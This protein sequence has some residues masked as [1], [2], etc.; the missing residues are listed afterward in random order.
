MPPHDDAHLTVHAEAEDEA[1]AEADLHA[2]SIRRASCD[3]LFSCDDTMTENALA[4]AASPRR[5][6]ID[7]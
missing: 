1:K 2:R 6:S 3:R 5:G 4:S 7:G